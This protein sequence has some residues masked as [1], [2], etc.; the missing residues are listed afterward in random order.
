MRPRYIEAV[1]DRKYESTML[2]SPS[3]LIFLTA[4]VHIQKM[5]YTYFCHE[6]QLPYDPFGPEKLK[7]WPTIV[8]VKM[9]D[10]ITENQ[11]IR[12][13]MWITKHFV[14]SENRTYIEVK[15]MVNDVIVIDGSALIIR[16]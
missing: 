1:F 16:L 10:M 8:N 15:S 2:N 6:Y 13:K 7:V 14:K 3:H 12:H 5:I 11:S 9:P 4:L